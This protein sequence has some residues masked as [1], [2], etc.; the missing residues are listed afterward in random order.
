MFITSNMTRKRCERIPVWQFTPLWVEAETRDIEGQDWGLLLVI[1]SRDG[2]KLRWSLRMSQLAGN[3]NVYQAELLKRGFRM[4]HNAQ[5][6]LYEY[7]ISAQPHKQI[8]RVPRSGWY[9][10][11][12]V[13][14][15][16][17]YGD[18]GGEEIIFQASSEDQSVEN[19]FRSGGSLG[20]WKKH[21]ARLCEE[22]SRLAFAVSVAFAGPL[23]RLFQHESG[24][25]HFTGNSSVGKSTLIQVAGS[26]CGG[27]GA[28]GFFYRTWRTTDSALEAVAKA[29]NDSLLCLDEIG[30]ASADVVAKTAYMLANGQGKGRARKDGSAQTISEWRLLFL[31]SGE[32]TLEQKIQEEGRQR[33]MAGQAVRV[34]DIPAD[35]GAGFGVFETLHEFPD[36]KALAEYLQRAACADYGVAFR[37]YLEE[38]T[39]HIPSCKAVVESWMQRFLEDAYPN[40]ADGQVKRVANRFSLV[41]GAGEL[42]TSLGILPWG[43]GTALWATREC[44]RAWVHS[45][46]GMGAAEYR[47]ALAKIRGFLAA[48]GSSR[49]EA[50]K[51][52]EERTVNRAGF[53]KQENGE[54][55]YLIF[56]D[57]F[58]NELCAGGNHLNIAK[59]LLERGYLVPG[60]NGKP[61]RVYKLPR[62]GTTARLFTI[63]ASILEEAEEE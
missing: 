58:K 28:S 31:S 44:F 63:K 25:F 30:Q 35:A 23:L 4:A 55:E 33:Y 47:E 59:Y 17:V 50:W 43:S 10:S 37:R 34:V 32:L 39:A 20:A 45:R 52:G 40:C 27:G 9:N 24:G 57:V 7:L 49:F 42:A 22:N 2:R 19:I 60:D 41:A 18:S 54:T 1:Q 21:V 15:D 53:R 12:Y 8:L 3:G 5:K 16:A 48:H 36:G 11:C 61:G 13:L 6:R 62:E 26:V 46:G 56:R 51:G 14:S 29:H 38:L